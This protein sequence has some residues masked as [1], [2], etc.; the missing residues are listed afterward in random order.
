MVVS[1]NCKCG[2]TD[3]QKV[4]EYHGW[5]G[6]E[7]LICRCCGRYSDHQGSSEP[8]EFSKQFVVEN[9]TS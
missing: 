2:N 5:V 8:D 6:Y 7:A 1:F 3:P 9:V 4:K